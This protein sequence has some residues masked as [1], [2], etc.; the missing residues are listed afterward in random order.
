MTYNLA[1]VSRE[2][3]RKEK[4]WSTGW[5]QVKKF[6]PNSVS[7]VI[8]IDWESGPIFLSQSQKEVLTQIMSLHAKGQHHLQLSKR[9][10]IIV[11]DWKNLVNTGC[12]NREDLHTVNLLIKLPLW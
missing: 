10:E 3:S 9:F 11:A 7:L 4:G 6:E 2:S 12:V 8:P 1:F 5:S